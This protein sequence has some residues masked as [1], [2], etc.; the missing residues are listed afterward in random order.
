MK[1]LF[2][3]ALG[4]AMSLGAAANA[5]SIADLGTTYDTVMTDF[6]TAD[7]FLDYQGIGV[8]DFVQYFDDTPPGA[9]VIEGD[10]S[11]PASFY[12]SIDVIVPSFVE[13]LGLSDSI[14]TDDSLTYLFETPTTGYL[15]T[16][17]PDAPSLF[18]DDL[19]FYLD[20]TVISI[21]KYTNAPA[22]VIPLPASLPLILAGLGGLGVVARRKKT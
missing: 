12:F 3:L 8:G 11:A 5:T 2:G 21:D 17:A 22:A 4:A 13:V 18:T 7:G 1:T 6:Y 9:I 15:V 19:E 16:L 20:T 10:I 14:V